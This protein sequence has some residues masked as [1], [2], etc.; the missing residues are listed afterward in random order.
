MTKSHLLVHPCLNTPEKLHL[1]IYEALRYPY[2]TMET[3]YVHGYQLLL[4]SIKLIFEN[5]SLKAEQKTTAACYQ[6][7]YINSTE[8]TV[9]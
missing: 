5:I 6:T 4:S 1:C 2:G 9:H 8:G 3:V 7:C